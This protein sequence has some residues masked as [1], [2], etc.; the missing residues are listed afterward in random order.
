MT[1][2]VVAV[3]NKDNKFQHYSV[4]EEVYTYIMQLEGAVQRPEESKIKERYPE[5]FKFCG[6]TTKVSS[7]C[8]GW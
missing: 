1:E 2:Y 8:D 3:K 6:T 4:P 5:R 7:G